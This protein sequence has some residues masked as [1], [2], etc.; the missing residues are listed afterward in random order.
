MMAASGGRKL[1]IAKATQAP[2]RRPG[3]PKTKVVSAVDDA[4]PGAERELLVVLRR[5]AATLL[6]RTNSPSAAERLMTQ[7]LKYDRQIRALDAEAAEAEAAAREA[8]DEADELEATD[9]SFDVG[10]I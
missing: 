5:K 7:L 6:D 3:R 10:A 9:D 2:A 8:Q 4:S 1:S